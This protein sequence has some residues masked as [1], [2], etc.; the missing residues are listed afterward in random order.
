MIAIW[1]TVTSLYMG[2]YFIVVARVCIASGIHGWIWGEKKK[3][4]KEMK[5][6]T[7]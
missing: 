1:A 4:E 3:K 2:V 7:K 6:L 5:N